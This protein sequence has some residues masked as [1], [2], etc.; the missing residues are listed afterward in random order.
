M[1]A[2]LPNAGITRDTFLRHLAASRLFGDA[3]LKQIETDH[4]NSDAIGL[5]HS[6]TV[7]GALTGY[8]IDAIGQGQTQNLRIGNYDILDRLGAGGMGTV[9]KARH[10]RMKRIVALKVLS[11][12]LSKDE[13]FV[14]RFQREVETIARLNH[15]NIVMAYDADEAENGHFLV[16]E[17]VDGRDLAS[18]IAKDGP[19]DFARAIDCTLQA[20]RGLAYA[21]S[22]DIIHRDIKP[23]NLLL[24][25]SGVVKV[26]DLGLA[27]LNPAAGGESASTGITQAGGILGTVDYM[28][29]EQAIDSTAIDH[30]AD[31]YSLGCVLYFLLTGRAIFAG[32]N[33]M[34][35]L[36]KHRESAIPSLFLVRND[37][38]AELDAVFQRMVAKSPDDRYATMAEVI[39]ALEKIAGSGIVRQA[40]P[41]VSGLP[42]TASTGSSV[43]PGRPDQKTI[44]T[45]PSAVKLLAALV[46]EPSRMQA[47]IVRKFLEAQKIE[48]TK[49]VATASEAIAAIRAK[50]SD[51]IV[52]ALHLDDM[53][54]IE[55]ANQVRGEFKENT[56]G[57]VLI[58]SESDA[59]DAEKISHLDRTL[60]LHKPFTAAQLLQ[61]IGV[62]TGKAP[63]LQS[64]DFSVDEPSDVL[65][66]AIPAARTNR[67]TL[68]VL[69]VDDSIVARTHERGVLQDL[70]FGNFVEV[71]DGAQAI[72]AAAR[73]RFDL[74]VTDYN[75]PLMDGHAFVT[76]LRQ[77][78]GTASVPVIMVTTEMDSKILNPIRRLGVVAIFS[79]AF[80]P[81][82]VRPVIDR[83]F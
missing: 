44:V 59:K 35:V 42:F 4:P 19:F 74:I 71:A 47:G 78:P 8:Q 15:P 34:S 32:G 26:T 63:S 65:P 13:S 27:R 77:T 7:V 21:H 1:D 12:A 76:Y 24:D 46:V 80:S 41:V 66:N 50:R 23:A 49:I 52:C 40:G 55:L 9:F 45:A 38:P 69:I 10:R 6:L 82:D 73:D 56:P 54:G 60:L 48:V 25:S 53:T 5:A 11:S 57:F 37:T 28:A 62:V 61:A 30:R 31:I 75:M 18:A 67:A 14:R 17:F 72:A 43:A 2:T 39:A 68:K 16:M 33:A 83:M 70:G 64:T 22:Q 81:D 3:E 20:A 79:K 29:P 36:V 58:S 51:A